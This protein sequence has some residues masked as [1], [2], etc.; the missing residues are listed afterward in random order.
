MQDCA[1]KLM[2][3]PDLRP[4]PEDPRLSSAWSGDIFMGILPARCGLLI[5]E[6]RCGSASHGD[7]MRGGSAGPAWPPRAAQAS[8]GLLDSP[9][10]CLNLN[11]F[12]ALLWCVPT[13]RCSLAMSA[14]SYYLQRLDKVGRRDPCPPAWS[15]CLPDYLD[16]PMAASYFLR[17]LLPALPPAPLP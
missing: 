1:Y 10:R 3:T 6:G 11:A 15:A 17:L 2:R 7:V 16:P 13:C 4:H 9:L 14:H 12:I 8:T 5:A